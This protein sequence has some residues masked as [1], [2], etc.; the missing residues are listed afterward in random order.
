[1]H[2][3]IK[4]SCAVVLWIDPQGRFRGTGRAA[5]GTGIKESENKQRPY[6]LLE[7]RQQKGCS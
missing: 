1:M 4:H 2:Y 5:G 3:K 6:C 7:Q